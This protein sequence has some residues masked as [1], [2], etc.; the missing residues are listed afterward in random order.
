[1]KV[2]AAIELCWIAGSGSEG[3]TCHYCGEKG[4]IRPCCPKHLSELT[5]AARLCRSIDQNKPKDGQPYKRLTNGKLEKW[6]AK[7]NQWTHGEGKAHTTAE[8]HRK[9]DRDTAFVPA[10]GNDE[11]TTPDTAAATGATGLKALDLS[12]EPGLNI[13]TFNN[14]VINI[15]R[16]ISGTGRVP[17]GLCQ[18]IAGLYVAAG[19]VLP[20]HFSMHASAYFSQANHGT[21]SPDKWETITIYL[22]CKYTGMKNQGLWP[23]AVSK[24]D[25]LG[26]QGLQAEV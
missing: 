26:V 10:T 25:E 4:H 16:R 14:K 18:V 22:D 13:T 7:C 24:L 21:L 15:G 9:A 3:Q 6:C 20:M 8:Y 12:K 19:S 23:A 2:K 1:M 17:D 11:P 5:N